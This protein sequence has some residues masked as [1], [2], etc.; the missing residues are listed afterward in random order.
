MDKHR[1][2]LVVLPHP[3][4]E[5]HSMSGSL[6]KFISEGVPVT[7]ACL[8]LGQMARNMGR[9]LFAN[10]ITL[11]GIRKLELLESCRSIGITDLRLLGFHDKM[12]E[13]EKD[14]D[15][16]APILALIEELK[17]SLIMTFYPGYS[18]HPDHDATGAAVVRAVAKLPVDERPEVH[19]VAFSKGCE[20]ILGKPDV[21][22][23]VRA[24]VKQKIGSIQAHR[25]QWQLD[26]GKKTANDR[27]VQERFGT[28]R[29]WTYR[30]G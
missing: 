9:P 18:V 20:D 21:V 29:F 13:F 27:E 24:F 28:E 23:D 30:F 15:V 6:A 11:P 3:D 5:C 16:E 26:L 7:Y 8:T 4:D 12:V 22:R 17:P 19:G 14:E 25:S 2:I 10:R 1:H